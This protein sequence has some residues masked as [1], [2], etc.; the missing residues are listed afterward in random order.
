MTKKNNYFASICKVSRAF[1][2]ASQKKEILDLIVDSAIKTMEVKAA[3]LFLL[4]EEKDIF[5]TAAQKGLSKD[6]LHSK[7]I[8]ARKMV[9]D[10]LKKG[11]LAVL[12]ATK[13]PRIEN[14]KAKKKEGIVS[15]LV[16]PVLVSGK[17]IGILSLYT[18][19]PRKFGADEIE[20]LS[21][22]AEQGGMAIENARLIERIRDF[23]RVFLDLSA[24]INSTLDLKTILQSLTKDVATAIG[25]KAASIRLL[26]EKK[27]TLQLAASYGLSDK[28]LNKGPI[29]AEKSIA[30]ALEGKPVVVK[31]ASTDKGVQYKKEKKEEGIVSI[32]CVPIKV[33]DEVIGVLRLYSSVAR[34]FSEQE[35]ALVTALANHGGLAIQ[36]AGQYLLLKNDVKDLKDNTW[37]YRSWF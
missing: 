15:L 26:N 34:E 31:N 1:G 20:F 37:S 36:N 4:D 21:A 24:N 28:Y 11:H 12:D 16:V 13:D 25:V 14:P 3:S 9:D 30:E 18:D 23:I 27:T 33:K 19:S 35:I 7:P 17:T 29:S 32:L 2:T 22:L 10:I 8:H 5:L 6:Y